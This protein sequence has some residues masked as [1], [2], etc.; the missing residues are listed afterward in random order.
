[1]AKKRTYGE[2]NKISLSHDRRVPEENPSNIRNSPAN[3]RENPSNRPGF[4][5]PT[6]RGNMQVVYSC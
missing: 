5:T 6:A 1:M 2:K 4:P 3:R